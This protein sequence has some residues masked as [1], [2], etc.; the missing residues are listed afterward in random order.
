MQGQRLKRGGGEQGGVKMSLLALVHTPP[1]T[2][3]SY[4]FIYSFIH[5][6]I[7]RQ[8][9]LTTV[10]LNSILFFVHTHT[11]AYVMMLQDSEPDKQ[12][13]LCNPVAAETKVLLI[14]V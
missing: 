1:I 13:Q 12:T 6:P 10:L 4:S 3:C 5:S 8:N 2:V 7:Q 11:Q 14:T 9:I